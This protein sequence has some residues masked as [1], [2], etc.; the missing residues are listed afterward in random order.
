MSLISI[1]GMGAVTCLGLGADRLWQTV[2]DERSGINKLGLGQIS[3][4]QI[5]E[6]KDTLNLPPMTSRSVVLGVASIA[7]AM[8]QAKWDDLGPDD[9]LIIGTTTGQIDLWELELTRYLNKELSPQE[10]G[11]SLRSQSLGSCAESLSRHLRFS[12]RKTT[13]TSAC[14]AG[15]QA[16][17]L[18]KQ[19]IEQGKVKRCLVGGVEILSRLTIEGFRSLQL[20]STKPA[21]PFDENRQGIN[22]AEGAAFFCLEKKSAGPLCHL[23]G[24]GAST[25]AYHMTAPHPDGFGSLRAMT[26]ALENSQLKTSD[27]DWVHAHG[28]GSRANDEA[29]GRAITTLFGVGRGPWVSSTKNIHGHALA[30]SGAIESVLCVQAIQKQLIL[31][32]SGLN[33]PDVDVRHPFENKNLKVK[34]I[35]KNTLGFGGNN[36]SLIFSHPQFGGKS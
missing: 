22:L 15:T 10:F 30:A 34:N 24:F 2:L 23:T 9:G 11:R 19:W 3:D 32:T 17:G 28:T 1:T 6:L 13:I 27:I 31:K 16:L 35:L 25:D 36:S 21:T 8:A 18:G 4:P 29:E 7:E 12:G 33:S 14:S 5:D 20:L 26:L